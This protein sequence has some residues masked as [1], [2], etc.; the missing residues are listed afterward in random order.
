MQEQLEAATR[1]ILAT[2]EVIYEMAREEAEGGLESGDITEEDI[3]SYYLPPESIEEPEVGIPAPIWDF[4]NGRLGVG[5]TVHALYSGSE[6][7]T[8][9]GELLT[10]VEAELDLGNVTVVGNDG[11]MFDIEKPEYLNW[12]WLVGY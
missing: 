3:L 9:T 6:P 12:K 11:L 2:S 7:E 8:N 1:F 5:K 10:V 4:V